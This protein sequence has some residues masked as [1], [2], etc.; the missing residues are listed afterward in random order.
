MKKLYVIMILAL[1]AVGLCAQEGLFG[2]AYGD[3]LNFADS[4][5]VQ[6]GFIAREVISSWVIYTSDYNPL[7]D[8]VVLYVDPATEILRGWSVVYNAENTQ[9]QD[10]YVLDMMHKMH[11][12]NVLVDEARETVS[13][14]FDENLAASYSYSPQGNLRVMYYDF[15]C[16]ELFALPGTE[17]EPEPSEPAEPDVEEKNQAR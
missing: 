11:G 9:E 16:P 5:M 6:Q 14:I 8:F 2:L 15:S 10:G 7:I 12:E 3:D 17:K 4:L 1:A 13:W